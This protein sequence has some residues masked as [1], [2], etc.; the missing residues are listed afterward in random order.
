M[1]AVG[2]Y[3]GDSPPANI[4]GKPSAVVDM[5]YSAMYDSDGVKVG[6]NNKAPLTCLVSAITK[7][8]RTILPL[9]FHCLIMV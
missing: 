4:H 1:G 2:D 8:I 6:P 5:K 9:T 3:V 7:T